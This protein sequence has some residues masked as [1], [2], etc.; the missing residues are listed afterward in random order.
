MNT[1]SFLNTLRQTGIE[2]HAEGKELKCSAPKGVMT[3]FLA[4]EI[5]VRKQE[6]LIFLQGS[7]STKWSS[8]VPIK[9][10]GNRPPFFCF[11][12]VGGN[13]LNYAVLSKFLDE[14]R[15]LYGLQS[16]GLDGLRPPLST[17][18]K[19][20]RNYIAE[21]Q[22]IQPRGPYHLG[23]GSMGGNIA[24]EAAQQLKAMGETI[25]TLILFDTF[26]PNL[27]TRQGKEQ[28]RFGHFFD[29]L[30]DLT[31]GEQF[32]FLADKVGSKIEFQRKLKECETCIKNKIPIPH[33]LRFWYIERQN[34]NALNSYTFNPYHEEII[35]FRSDMKPE[36]WYS[37]PKRGWDGIATRLTIQP[38]P[39]D[40]E[41][42]I[43][44]PELGKHLSRILQDSWQDHA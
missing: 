2:L 25:G 42:L 5:K 36:G 43:E 7:N 19:M 34:Y 15:P 14:E 31:I 27:Q 22:T 26:G 21:I 18:E 44:Q 8:L 28:T 12:G 37:D 23:G 17:I 24:F 9:P 20:A 3:P 40:H 16:Q 38:V 1:A 39:G 33:D 30:S 11:H 13:V 41:N 4:Q 10:S 32:S 29:Q 6:I 35:L